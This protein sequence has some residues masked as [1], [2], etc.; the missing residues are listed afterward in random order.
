LYI[1]LFHSLR[2]NVGGKRPIFMKL[3]MSDIPLQIDVRVGRLY[4]ADPNPYTLRTVWKSKRCPS[5]HSKTNQAG[6][7]NGVFW[8]VTPC[9]SCKNRR[10]GGIL[11]KEALISSETSVL[12]RATRRNIP[13]DTILDSHRR[14]NLKSE[15]G[16]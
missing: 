5:H 6:T 11:M 2:D 12:T 8:D 13:E 4:I 16:G 9:G 3:G 15:T 7:T 1:D 10:F 14:E